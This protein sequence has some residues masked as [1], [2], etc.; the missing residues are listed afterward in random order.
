MDTEMKPLS[1]MDYGYKE[2]AKLDNW[3]FNLFI[4]F[5]LVA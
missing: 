2:Q 1:K 5:V 3:F 4:S